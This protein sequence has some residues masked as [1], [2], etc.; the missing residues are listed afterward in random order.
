MRGSGRTPAQTGKQGLYRLVEQAR[1]SYKAEVS[2]RQKSYRR[3]V[4]DFIHSTQYHDAKDA[5]SKNEHQKNYYT[6]AD[7]LSDHEKL[8]RKYF[9]LEVFDESKI[10]DLLDEFYA[11]DLPQPAAPGTI[12]ESIATQE[13]TIPNAAIESTLDNR[14][15]DL[16]AQ[17]VNEVDLFKEKLDA[18]DTAARY[19]AGTLR[20]V[21]SRNNARL[22]LLL[23]K[24]AS[25]G[26]IPYGWQVMIARKRL[27]V[28]S[29]GR[30]YLDQHDMSSTLNRIK[31]TQPGVSEKK[32]LAT[33]DRYIVR[34]KNKEM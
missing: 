14:T 17:L 4:L 26:I 8:V 21:T 22:V 16:I 34:I 7:L 9:D 10:S 27:I 23:D 13:S 31:D 33:I 20:A 2:T 12:R 3:Y 18:D 6:V 19:A 11:F 30:K 28:S 29:S 5:R 32:L 24:L 1:Q 15:I 25:R